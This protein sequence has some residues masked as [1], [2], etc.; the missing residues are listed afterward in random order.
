VQT[1]IRHTQTIVHHRCFRRRNTVVARTSTFHQILD[2]S[3]STT[4][5][6]RR[7][8]PKLDQSPRSSRIS[9][10]KASTNSTNRLSTATAPQTD[11]HGRRRVQEESRRRPRF[12]CEQ[13]VIAPPH[14]QEHLLIRSS[15]PQQRIPLSPSPS[16]RPCAAGLLCLTAAGRPTIRARVFITRPYLLGPLS[17]NNLCTTSRQTRRLAPSARLCSCTP[18]QAQRSQDS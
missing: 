6:Y 10:G 14:H 9:V 8:A 5:Y 11:P 12:S 18:A 15:A 13:R 7:A 4:T 17:N 3:T 2:D 1:A 16:P